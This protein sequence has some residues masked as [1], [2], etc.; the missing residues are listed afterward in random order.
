[1]NETERRGSITL[2]SSV[3]AIKGRINSMKSPVMDVV[4]SVRDRAASMR[5]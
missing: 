4:G 5:K 2:G 1:M 3:A